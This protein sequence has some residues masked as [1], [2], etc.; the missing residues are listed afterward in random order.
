VSYL[1]RP[2]GTQQL[3]VFSKV[4]LTPGLLVDFV[5]ELPKNYKYV[6]VFLNENNPTAGLNP[7]WLMT[8]TNYVLK[9]NRPYRTI[10][11]GY[12]KQTLRNLAKAKKHQHRIF[13]YDS[14]EQLVTL[15]RANRGKQISSLTDANYAKILHIMHVMLH[16]RRGYLWTIYDEYNTIIAG[17][18]FVEMGGRITLLFSATNETGKK[19]HAM[20]YLLDELFIARAGDDVLFDFEG[21]NIPS[22]AQ[23]YAGFGAEART[24]YTLRINLLPPP[25][26]W[27]KK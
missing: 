21:S 13:E 10:F 4:A 18:Y 5:M 20:T 3:G 22:L 23:F 17:A 19:H 1:F 2:Y 8:N 27:L 26:R 9:L 24:Y 12:S 6:E 7:A 15:F 11:E 16:K 14:P 25:F